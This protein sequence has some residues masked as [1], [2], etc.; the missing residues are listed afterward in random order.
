MSASPALVMFH[1]HDVEYYE[2][3]AIAVLIARE[4]L[5]P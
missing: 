2:E 5:I 1:Y 4:M 3:I